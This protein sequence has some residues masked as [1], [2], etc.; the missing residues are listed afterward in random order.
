MTQPLEIAQV[1]SGVEDSSG[2]SVVDNP[3]IRNDTT[4]DPIQTAAWAA[5]DGLDMP[6]AADTMPQVLAAKSFG[7]VEA[8]E[9]VT[10]LK[11]KQ[12]KTRGA[13]ILR[14]SST[15]AIT[16]AF[17]NTSPGG[18]ETK[19]HAPDLKRKSNLISFSAK[20]PRNQ[21]VASS[22]KP[23]TLI[24][25]EHQA[26]HT[27]YPEKRQV[28]KLE[29]ENNDS[30][31]VPPE[32]RPLIEMRTIA[33]AGDD[34]A[35]GTA[36]RKSERRV[37]K[38]TS[39]LQ[40][41]MLSTARNDVAIT[42]PDGE[43]ENALI[44]R[45]LN[46]VPVAAAP[47]LAAQPF[48]PVANM[49][50]N[51][52]A[53]SR[54]RENKVSTSTLTTV[55]VGLPDTTP[56]RLDPRPS[57]PTPRL[58]DATPRENKRQADEFG[59]EELNDIA[60]GKR[61]KLFTKAPVAEMIVPELVSKRNRSIEQNLSQRT[62]SQSVRVNENGSP[63]PLARGND[64]AKSQ[65][66]LT[67][68]IVRLPAKARLDRVE[69]NQLTLPFDESA[70]DETGITFG[71]VSRT[72]HSKKWP[73]GSSGN[74]KL[75][76]SSPNASSSIVDEME[77]HHIHPSGKF[78]N[79][80][81]ENVITAHPPP[82]PFVGA[83]K[84]QSNTFIDALRRTNYRPHEFPAKDPRM[85]IVGGHKASRVVTYDEDLN[86][87]DEDVNEGNQDLEK[88]LVEPDAQEEHSETASQTSS[89]SQSFCSED[90]LPSRNRSGSTHAKRDDEWR[91][92][93]QPHQ[94]DT[95]DVLYDVSHVSFPSRFPYAITNAYPNPSTSYATLSPK[96]PQFKTSLMTTNVAVS[97]FSV[98]S[99]MPVKKN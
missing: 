23:E 34:R 31:E 47:T 21:G 66:R 76:P 6:R 46:T 35:P 33:L 87:G 12:R 71:Q 11:S 73:L 20:G 62:G 60:L 92:A 59:V 84:G 40:K 65:P 74:S 2:E 89:T 78:I 10:K 24:V 85:S 90:K 32:D 14:P 4:I 42:S 19:G 97:V 88:T 3:D 64:N 57:L 17:P 16:N 54:R 80:E 55:P 69:R 27:V 53:K 79:V 7:E 95:L 9:S 70:L 22:Q 50:S 68:D 29:H 94:R 58:V 18:I 8:S 15:K 30:G 48:V 36:P 28:Y 96:K 38:L 81:T 37:S 52:R 25:N 44:A 45:I 93:L 1:S 67:Q 43:V 82:D 99:R 39:K 98:Y 91:E 13:E 49:G 26:A 61:R 86:E 56:A 77:P 72:S 51:S 63:V 83:A 5:Q 75:Q 41:A